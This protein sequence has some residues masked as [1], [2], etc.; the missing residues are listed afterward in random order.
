MG[1]RDFCILS[2]MANT[3][4]RRAEVCGL[5]RKDLKV[6]GKK[7]VLFI[8]G[9]G[10]H[11]RKSFIKNT[12]LILALERYFKMIGN[13]ENP[14]APMFYQAKFQKTAGPQRMSVSTIRFLVARHIK[15]ANIQKHITAHSLRH[16]FLTLALQSGADLATVKALA[17][18][19]SVA[20]TSRYLH[21]S[22]ELMEKAIERLAL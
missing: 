12:E 20:T 4:L 7:L 18:H 19:A 22:E 14:E 21:T 2:L 1:L 6:E 13:P 8:W 11:Q 16:T 10:G 3:G 9:K 15:S 5:N 17:G